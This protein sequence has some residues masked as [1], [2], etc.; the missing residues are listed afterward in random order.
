M[1]FISV[2]RLRLRSWR[3]VPSFVIYT[4]GSALQVRRAAGFLAGYVGT[5]R[6]RGFWTVTSW[7]D[8]AAMKS[9]RAAGTHLK[10]MAKLRTWCDEASI[11]HWTQND[12]AAP[13]PDIAFER[14]RLQGR[15]S[16]VSAPSMNHQRG[17]VV[18]EAAPRVGINL[19]RV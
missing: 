8:E 5:D 1:P 2:T 6:N 10:A 9:Y 14:M 3:F 4:V 7:A 19:R 11:A 13:T 12:A 17:E 15:T 18:G 16:K